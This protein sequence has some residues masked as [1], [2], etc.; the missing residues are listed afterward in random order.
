MVKER[1]ES[2]DLSS[3]DESLKE[4]KVVEKP[5]QAKWSPKQVFV[6]GLPY[7]TTEEQ[8]KEFFDEAAKDI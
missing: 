6:S 2:E 3:S 8:L 4:K 7:E 5:V 1:K